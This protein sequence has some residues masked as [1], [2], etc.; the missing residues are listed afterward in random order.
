[1]IFS[2]KKGDAWISWVLL[3][4]FSVILAAITSTWL[5]N[6]AKDSASRADDQVQRSD[7]CELLG[8]SIDFVCQRTTSPKSLNMNLTNRKDLKI[9]RFVIRV[10]NNSEFQSSATLN[11]IIKPQ[12]TKNVTVNTTTDV[13]YV[14][15]VPVRIDN[16][17][18]KTIMCAE[19]LAKATVIA[20]S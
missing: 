16:V 15:V 19:Q 6:Y 3:V 4:A 18:N 7:T 9:D 10:Y 20:C 8:V 1:M 12:I 17:K 2:S 14:E 5:Q 13:D 11:T